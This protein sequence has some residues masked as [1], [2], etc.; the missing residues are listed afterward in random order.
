MDR[1]HTL[2][3]QLQSA[4]MSYSATTTRLAQRLSIG[5]A[6]VAF[7]GAVGLGSYNLASADIEEGARPVFVPINPCRLIDTRPDTPIGNAATI[8]VAAHGSNGECTGA[9]TIPTDAVAL[10]LN[11]TATGASSSTFLTFW[12][13]GTNPGTSNLNPRPGAA[14]T[15]NS[16]NT[17]L[18]TAGNFNIYNDAGTVNVIVDVNG[19]YANHNHDDRYLTE[20]E[21]EVELEAIDGRVDVVEAKIPFVAGGVVTD[22]DADAPT[23]TFDGP[24]G[25]TASV[26]SGPES[27]AYI[28]TI[29]GLDEQS[30]K[31][32]QIT[33]FGDTSPGVGSGAIAC[34]ISAQQS[35]GTTFAFGVGC[36]GENDTTPGEIIAED[37]SFQFLIAG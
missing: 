29:V 15:P 2:V 6:A 27:G 12:G 33:A 19:Y 25:A 37:A 35:S 4:T 30:T 11:V 20:T 26:T 8:T 1:R 9:S 31:N 32:V 23:V 5:V 7:V 18:S 24:V 36:F 17:P 14:P 28:V 21:T 22:T 10:A 13:D 34:S 16:V 3:E